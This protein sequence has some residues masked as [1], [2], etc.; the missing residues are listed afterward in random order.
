MLKSAKEIILVADSSKFNR[1]AFTAI[2]PLSVVN[3]LVTDDGLNSEVIARLE[4]QG[5]DVILA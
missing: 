2:A 5:L 3:R 4:S 1:V